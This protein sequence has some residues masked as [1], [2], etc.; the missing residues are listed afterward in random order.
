M[1][2]FQDASKLEEY[3]RKLGVDNTL[4]N[5]SGKNWIF[6]E[7]TWQGTLVESSHQHISIN[8]KQ[9]GGLIEVIIRTIYAKCDDNMR[10]ELWDT[11]QHIA[12]NKKP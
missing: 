12:A 5:A 10:E 7:N 8:F 11:L 1:E 9:E 3:K 2:P 6:W 4:V